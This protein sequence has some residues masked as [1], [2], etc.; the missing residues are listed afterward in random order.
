MPPLP[1]T[2]SGSTPR[3][4]P[5]LNE[6]FYFSEVVFDTVGRPCRA[7]LLHVAPHHVKRLNSTR[8][9]V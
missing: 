4:P 6:G 2:E 8:L 3:V 5:S 1:I 7:E 9:R